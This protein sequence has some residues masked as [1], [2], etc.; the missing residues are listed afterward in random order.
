[1]MKSLTIVLMLLCAIDSFAQQKGLRVEINDLGTCAEKLDT[2]WLATDEKETEFVIDDKYFVKSF[3]DKKV[4]YFQVT[5]SSNTE[6]TLIAWV[7]LPYPEI[8][9]S[10]ANLLQIADRIDTTETGIDLYV[11]P[12]KELDDPF[13]I[14][15]IPSY[16]LKKDD[17]GNLYRHFA[18][19]ESSQGVTTCKLHDLYTTCTSDT[20]PYDTQLMVIV[21]EIVYLE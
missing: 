10:K 19:C 15:T 7:S 3:Y 13:F 11:G 20:R 21:D 17:D 4:K 1:M 14:F 12:L 18:T 6:L 2:L 16:P 8:K 9:E 5:D